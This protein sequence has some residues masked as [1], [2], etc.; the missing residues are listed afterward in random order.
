MIGEFTEELIGDDDVKYSIRTELVQP[1]PKLLE[2]KVTVYW[3]GGSI[4]FSTVKG[5]VDL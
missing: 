1:E 2:I 3:A 4:S 5:D